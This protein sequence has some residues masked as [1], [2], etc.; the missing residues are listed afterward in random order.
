[1]FTALSR[2]LRC[3]QTNRF[4]VNKRVSHPPQIVEQIDHQVCSHRDQ[5]NIRRDPD[6]VLTGRRQSCFHNQLSSF[7]RTILLTSLGLAV[8][9]KEEISHNVPQCHELCF[10]VAHRCRWQAT[11]T[12][13]P[14][15]SHQRSRALCLHTEFSVLVHARQTKSSFS[16]VSPP[17]E[18]GMTR[19]WRAASRVLVL[20]IIARCP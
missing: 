7:A 13:S 19:S 4:H 8:R 3:R 9:E 14:A 17:S 6:I 16:W 10:V 20:M 5:R 11:A 1:M 15:I 12:T 2:R 18:C